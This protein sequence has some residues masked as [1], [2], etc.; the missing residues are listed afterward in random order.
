[1]L[2]AFSR[3]LNSDA[4]VSAI[5]ALEALAHERTIARLKQ[6]VDELVPGSPNPRRGPLTPQTLS[7]DPASV[8]LLETIVSLV[9]K[10]PQ[11]L[12]ETWYVSDP[13]ISAPI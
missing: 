8:Y 9:S 10:R 7:Y 5:R 2:T 11:F 1:M 6:E 13:E 12:E 3:E 4:F